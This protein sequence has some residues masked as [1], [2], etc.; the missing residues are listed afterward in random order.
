[1]KKIAL[2][3]LLCVC[4]LLFFAG[5]GYRFSPGGEWIPS[6]IKTV[7]V[8]NMVNST[9]EALIDVYL[10]TGF[11]LQLQRSTRLKLASSRETADAILQGTIVSVTT[12]HVSY[13]RYDR[14]IEDRAIMN[15][16]LRFDERDTRKTLWKVSNFSGYETYRVDQT[17]PNVSQVNK[18]AALQKLSNDMSEKAFRNLMSG[19]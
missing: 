14:A 7:Y 12:I 5:C 15:V 16:D 11:E 19:F 1:M 4:V 6:Q 10:R 9:P 18:T 3:I 17:N 13:D 8:D 2:K